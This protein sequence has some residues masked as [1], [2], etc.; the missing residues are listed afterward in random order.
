MGFFL[1]GDGRPGVMSMKEGD[2]VMTI[3][4]EG[5]DGASEAHNVDF[6][7]I[8]RPDNYFGFIHFVGEGVL[9]DIANTAARTLAYIRGNQLVL[10]T[11]HPSHP[12]QLAVI[13]LTTY[14][15]HY[16]ELPPPPGVFRLSSTV[17]GDKIFQFLA[18]PDKIQVEVDH[19]P[20]LTPLTV[21]TW[22]K[23]KPPVFTMAPVR[24]D[25]G[26]TRRA[27]ET[28]YPFDK[29]IDDLD[30]C[31][32]GIAVDR[33][34]GGDYLLT[35]GDYRDPQGR[36]VNGHPDFNLKGNGDANSVIPEKHGTGATMGALPFV[37]IVG[38]E[39]MTNRHPISFDP[40]RLH[41]RS[42]LIKIV[43]DGRT[44]ANVPGKISPP[45][46]E[47]LAGY[48]FMSDA[49]AAPCAFS[50]GGRF[51]QGFFDRDA[52]RFIIREIPHN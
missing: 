29:Y 12:L 47:H 40:G 30:G 14:A 1:D 6:G 46:D 11:H 16:K 19:I 23:T 28:S 50:A 49:L 33:A 37:G 34:P 21:L 38:G 43:L 24:Y 2:T 35:L 4:R 45:G 25:I 52:G 3:S 31:S 15:V 32:I 8:V 26:E 10:F 20:D 9:Q 36:Y 42:S 7:D 13:D 22:T 41:F 39:A 48:V 18:Y 17:Y 5:P 44:L 51:Y 27:A